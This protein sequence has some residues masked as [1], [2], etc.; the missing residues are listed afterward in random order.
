MGASNFVKKFEYIPETRIRP[1]NRSSPSVIYMDRYYKYYI[2]LFFPRHNNV[3]VNKHKLHLLIN[4]LNTCI[5]KYCKT[6]YQI[7]CIRIYHGLMC[8]NNICNFP[9]CMYYKNLVSEYNDYPIIKNNNPKKFNPVHIFKIP[10]INKET[11]ILK[12]LL[13]DGVN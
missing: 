3:N 4:H 5:N 10:I 1:L 6:C 7:Y 12:Y 13:H 2:K 11:F 9:S 8:R